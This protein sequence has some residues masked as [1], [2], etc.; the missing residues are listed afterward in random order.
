M[1]SITASTR[2]KKRE[3]VMITVSFGRFRNSYQILD[4]CLDLVL[5]RGCWWVHQVH[6]TQK[7]S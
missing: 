6:T 3:Q 7:R 2:S 4:I 5:Q 1:A